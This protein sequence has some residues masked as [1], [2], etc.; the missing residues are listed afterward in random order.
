[1]NVLSVFDGMSCGQIALT[2]MGVKI[3]RYYA[4]E[5]DKHAIKLT[6]HNFPS[7]VQLGDVTKW[8]QWDID[9]E[10]IDLFL[11]GSP[12]QGFSFAGK[13][14]AFDDPRSKLFFVFVDIWNHIKKHNPNAHFLLENVR[15]KHDHE[16]VIT[17]FMGVHPI[18]INSALVSAQNRVRLYWTNIK[19]EPY[20][21][22]GDM[23]CTIEQPQD[24]G[25]LLRD[26]LESEV[27]EKYFLSEKLLSYF[28]KNTKNMKQSGNGFKFNP[29]EGFCK[30]KCVTTKEGSRMDDNFIVAS[31]GIGE[32]HS[33]ITLI[34][35]VKF[36]RT[37]EAKE[38]RKQN[39]AKG[40]DH[41]PHAKK[42]IT[43]VDL[44]KMNTLTTAVNK[45]NLII[46]HSLQPRQGKGR[47][48]RLTPLECQ[49]LQTVPE[50]YD[51]TVVS[52]TQR[53]RA[54]GNGWTVDVIAHIL[55]HIQ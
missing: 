43:S 49:R 45:D 11:G 54:L 47:I 14:L 5:I 1:M 36:G 46:T 16:A 38:I 25:I 12:C 40:V 53:Y 21:L 20:G 35:C 9:W 50:W 44:N 31:R 4:A 26:V 23:R 52:D 6:Q 3:G 48:R 39:M 34:G 17:R 41:T 27:D 29:T 10:G 19:N 37:D 24:R 7:T 33:D 32:F 30:S 55:K 15:M 28:I 51:M 8:Q 18:M 22:F 42:E 13:Q 2:E